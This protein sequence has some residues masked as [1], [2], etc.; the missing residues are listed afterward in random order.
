M[1]RGWDPVPFSRHL[2]HRRMTHRGFLTRAQAG[3]SRFSLHPCL[4]RAGVGESRTSGRWSPCTPT[5]PHVCSSTHD[6]GLWSFWKVSYELIS[7]VQITTHSPLSPHT[8]LSHRKK[9]FLWT[10]SVTWRDCI[11]ARGNIFLEALREAV[12][13]MGV[14]V[15]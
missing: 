9:P 13:Q 15:A 8:F 3:S 7:L 5:P 12:L 10:L 11:T 1:Q 2:G 4:V 14:E 6:S